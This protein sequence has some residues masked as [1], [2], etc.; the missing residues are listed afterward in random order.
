MPGFAVRTRRGDVFACDLS[1]DRATAREVPAVQGQEIR[2]K[3]RKFVLTVLMHDPDYDLGEDDALVSSKLVDSFAL[4][5][6]GI[7]IEEAFGVYIPDAE[8]TVKN[9]D[10]LRQITERVM[11]DT[12]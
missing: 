12:R 2:D 1:L 11:R 7:F 9:M 10:T 8:L 5:E 4:A 6:M 3:L